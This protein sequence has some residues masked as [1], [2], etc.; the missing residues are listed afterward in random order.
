MTT[1]PWPRR[2][3]GTLPE[4]RAQLSKDGATVRL[5]YGTAG[6]PV[7]ELGGLSI[8]AVLSS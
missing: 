6:D 2:G 3:S 1:A 4:P 8:A 7:L 5:F